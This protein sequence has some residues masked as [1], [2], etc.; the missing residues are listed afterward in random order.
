VQGPVP[1]EPGEGPAPFAFAR[2][3]RILFGEGRA[4][5]LPAIVRACGTRALVFVRGSETG[6]RGAWAAIR[7]TLEGAGLELI[8]EHVSGEPSPDLVDSIVARVRAGGDGAAVIAAAAAAGRPIRPPVD[9]VVGIGGGSVMDTAKAVA[10]LLIPGN[11]VMDHLEGVGP[12]RPYRGPATPFIAVPTTAGT[13]SEATKNAVLSTRGIPAFKKS[14][15][16]DALVAQVAVVDPDLLATCPPALIAGNGMDALTQL[17]E[18]YLSIRANPLTDAIALS[19]LADVR[20]GLVTWHAEAVGGRGGDGRGSL[21]AVARSRMAYAALCSGICLANAGLGAVHG[22]VS[23]L[24][25]QFPVPHGAACGSVLAAT[26]RANIAAL[27]ARAPGGEA[28]ARYADVGRVLAGNVR[29]TDPA[30]RAA[31]VGLLEDWRVRL[32]IPSLSVFGIG[33][34]D[35]PAIL[36]DSR[37]SSMKTNPVVLTDTEIAAIIRASL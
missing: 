19:A 10:G 15:R 32:E 17:I 18:A 3:P 35:I 12:E 6:D 34:E 24:G 9:V 30:A 20:D 27:D 33:E 8:V 23:P 16:D 37:G 13:G 2:A 29:L 26:T 1:T 22:L 14:F 11:S 4:A 31:L 25:A 5:E 36:A 28:L 7:P 21:A